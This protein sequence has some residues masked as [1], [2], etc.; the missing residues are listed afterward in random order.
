MRWS[1]SP[2]SQLRL[3]NLV[4]VAL[5][6]AGI[7]L[8][9]WIS[10]RYHLRFD[11]TQ[12]AANSLSAASVAAVERLQGPITITAFANQNGETRRLIREMIARYQ[13]HK[14]DITLEFID[15]DTNPESVRL[16]GVQ[17]EGELI[18][19]FGEARENIPPN[20]LTEENVTNALTRLGHRGERWLVFLSGHGE[21][22][23][24][25]PANF[26][27]STWSAQLRQRGFNTRSLTLGESEIPGNTTALVVAGPRTRLLAGEVRAIDAYLKRGG[28][29]LWLAD[30]GP[31][32]GLEPIA[33]SLGVELQPGVLVDPASQA[34]TGNPAAIIVARYG[35]HPVVRNFAE[36]T[37]FPH[38]AGLNLRP[39]EGWKTAVLLDTRETSWSET[40]TLSGAIGFDKGKDVPGPLVL[41]AT[42]TRSIDGREQ[43]VVVIGDGDFLSN[44]IVTNGGNLEFGMSL[45]NWLSRD[46]AYVSIPVR[47][48]RDRSL[49]LSAGARNAIGLG[50]LFVLPLGLIASGVT[51]WWRRRK[52]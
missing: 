34:V 8:L 44:T 13:P 46:D 24:D 7:G 9:Q 15:P 3:I 33:E 1:P 4:F 20:A 30:P 38:A 12:N 5:F 42:L 27:L 21:R 16:A 23:P 18:I 11:W 50:F 17:Y 28:N 52:R 6:F 49:T 31:L 19:A 36:I 47:T 37:V 2:R 14:P 48:A 45:A 32:Q 40:G 51:I 41:G 35:S 43:R 10:Q 26:D 22:S 29:L 25:R 39:A